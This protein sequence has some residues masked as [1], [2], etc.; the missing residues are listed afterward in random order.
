[1]NNAHTQT[2]LNQLHDFGWMKCKG[3][4]DVHLLIKF[5]QGCNHTTKQ[6]HKYTS[7]KYSASGS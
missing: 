2:K 3:N 5:L 1:V 7:G 6:L 4:A